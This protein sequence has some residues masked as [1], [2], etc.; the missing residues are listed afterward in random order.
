MKKLHLGLALTLFVV[1]CTKSGD[2]SVSPD[3]SAVQRRLT[4]VHFL[5]S[6]YADKNGRSPANAEELRAFGEAIPTG[7][8]GPVSLTAEVLTSPRD[9]LPIVV[10]YGILL[11]STLKASTAD[12]TR[13][14][15][16]VIAYEAVGF[17][18]KR[19]VVFAGSRRIDEV[20]ESAFRGL[21]P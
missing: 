4:A 20:E 15:G 21:V 7:E 11:R 10:R 13:E 12:A 9:G 16:P 6:A 8:G 2:G 5:Y 18:G 1:G 3:G 19:F 14:E 17:N